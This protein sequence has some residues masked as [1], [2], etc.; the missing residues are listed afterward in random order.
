VKRKAPDGTWLGFADTYGVATEVLGYSVPAPDR[1]QLWGSIPVGQALTLIASMLKDLDLAE[2]PQ[3]AIEAGWVDQLAEGGLRKQL[4]VALADDIR[5]LPPQLLLLAALEAIEHCPP[6]NPA[7]DFAGL[8]VIFKT[9]MGI[10]QDSASPRVGGENWGDLDSGLA[11]ELVAQH[12]FGHTVSPI[13]QLAWVNENWRA[14]WARPTVKEKL[15]KLA[16]GEPRELFLE[17]TGIEIDDFASIG[18]HLWVQAQQH[19]FV[20]FPSAFFD[21]LSIH[22]A[23]VDR[24]LDETSADLANLKAEVAAERVRTGSSRWAFHALR[25]YPIIRFDNGEWLVLRIGF[26]IQRALGDVTYLDVRNYLRDRDAAAGTKRAVGFRGCL[27]SS[28]EA[29][30]GRTLERMFPQVSS[31]RRVFDEITM[32]KTWAARKGQMPSVCDFAV[33]CGDVWLLFDVTDRRIPEI[34]I[35]GTA[36]AAELDSELDVVLTEKKAKQFAATVRHLNNEGF[37]LTKSPSVPGALFVCVVVTP[38]GGLGW[39]PAINKRAQERLD[40]LVVLQSAKVLSLSIMSVRDLTELEGAVEGGH[41][42]SDLLVEWRR[43]GP[44]FSFEQLLLLLK[45]P[46]GRSEFVQSEGM[47][48][49]D[50]LVERLRTFEEAADAGVGED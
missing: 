19:G 31:A 44:Q 2:V 3:R 33:D 27:G 9:V 45:V 39:N 48:L 14:P 12:Y 25:R 22:R 24:F 26:V 37:K 38:T 20:R 7:N 8:D 47:R 42:A 32:Q 16:G 28:L 10:A 21:R 18:V 49:I 30:V 34:L 29:S 5:L 35:N 43:N 36:G 23:A 41:S 11:A 50:E 40:S 17:A 4:N 46:L 15:I 6:G 1:M 13:D